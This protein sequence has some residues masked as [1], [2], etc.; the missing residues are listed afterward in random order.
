MSIESFGE[1]GPKDMEQWKGLKKVVN[2]VLI[3]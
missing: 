3:L 2:L 1:S